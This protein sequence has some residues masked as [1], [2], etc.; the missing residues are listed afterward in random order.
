VA[1]F[2]IVIGVLVLATLLW[3]MIPGV[4][5]AGLAALQGIRQMFRRR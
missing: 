3:I 4:S 2:M 5:S 1:V